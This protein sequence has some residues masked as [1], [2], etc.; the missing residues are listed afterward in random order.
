[1][2]KITQLFSIFAGA[3]AL[4][5]SLAQEHD[6]RANPRPP[7][8]PMDMNGFHLGFPDAYVIPMLSPEDTNGEFAGW[9]EHI[10]E[11]YYGPPH[12]H[13]LKSET[14]IVTDGIIHMRV[15]GKDYTLTEGQ[16]LYIPPGNVHAFRS[17][18]VTAKFIAIQTPG[19]AD[20]P[21][22]DTQ[23]CDRSSFTPEENR[24]PEII[25]D[26]YHNCA[27]DFYMVPEHGLP[28]E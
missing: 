23:E 28:F 19:V 22:P 6:P 25:S 18:A 17:S 1:M 7:I 3:F 11:D 24:D 16:W 8:R 21:P 9:V 2:K 26:W 4:Q 14:V 13:Y 10:Q 12:V 20:E 15:A 5:T 27:Y